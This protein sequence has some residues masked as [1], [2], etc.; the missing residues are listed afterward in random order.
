[1]ILGRRLTQTLAGAALDPDAQPAADPTAIDNEPKV[2][3]KLCLWARAASAATDV[4]G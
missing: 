4:D 3:M 2:Q 1:M